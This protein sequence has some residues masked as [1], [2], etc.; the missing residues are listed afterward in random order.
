MK[1]MDAVE[2]MDDRRNSGLP[3][4]QAAVETRDPPVGMKDV[5]CRPS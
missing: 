2:R 4:G 3:S 1:I 5:D